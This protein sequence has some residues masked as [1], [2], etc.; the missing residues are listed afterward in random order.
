MWSDE[1]DSTAI[2]TNNWTVVTGNGCGGSSGC[3][4]GNNEKQFYT[5]SIN[6]VNVTGGNL[7]LTARYQKN[8]QSSGSD[9]TSGK[10]Y[11]YQKHSWKYG[12]YEARIKVPSASAVWPAFWMLSD[13]NNWPQSGEIDILETQNKNPKKA[14]QTVHFYCTPC[15]NHQYVYNDYN[16]GTDWSADY[17]IYA[18]DWAPQEIKFSVDG[19]VTKTITPA[20]IAG[21]GATASDW[22]FDDS[23]F[24]I[25]LNLAVGGTYTGNATP[26]SSD[27]PVSMYV[28]YVR[29]YTSGSYLYVG[30]KEL[31]F[32][33]DTQTYTAS[34][35][36][37]NATY[38]WTV[39]SGASIESGQGTKSI[40]VK[41]NSALKGDISCDITPSGCSM[42]TAKLSVTAIDKSCS[43]IMD[44][45]EN[46]R[47]LSGA[48][49]DGSLNA[50]ITNSAK[51]GSNSSD[52]CASYTRNSGSQYDILGFTKFLVA[53][54]DD[55]RKGIRQ[56]TMDVK[57]SA[58]QGTTI[59]IEFDKVADLSK[60]WPY[61][62]HSQYTATTGAP[63]TWTK[64]TFKW[65]SSPDG[66][67]KG[68]DV[69]KIQIL[70]NSNSFTN[71]TYYFDNL[72]IEGTPATSAITGNTT[73]C[74]NKKGVAYSVT[75]M[76]G[77]TFNW[78]VPSGATIASGQ[79]TKNITVDFDT[80]SGNVS[81]VETSSLLCV[82]NTV[83]KAITVAKQNCNVGINEISN[84]QINAFPNPF[85]E[86]ISLTFEHSLNSSV[87]LTIFNLNGS[88]AQQHNVKTN[89]TINI[90]EDLAQGTY[91][92]QA[93][94]ADQVKTLRIVKM[95]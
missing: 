65:V 95:D 12:H 69:D 22:T 75:G 91:I 78:T 86:R 84:A 23:P 46:N 32:T 42:T 21:K 16:T 25:I 28:D 76:S 10:I 93:Q 88:V 11:T 19:V 17:H 82:G 64:L 15:G 94:Y 4:F 90:G 33:N 14:S 8:Y 24:Y 60:G 79:G 27:Y 2:N 57:T 68:S 3:G 56:F 62:R 30:G 74:Y 77:S 58:P 13:N 70:F 6:N 49:S 89:E 80:I 1:F 29:V 20:T 50:P 40:S 73:V 54:P 72:K 61:G 83:S 43:I 67:L 7:V 45:F 37:A 53:D 47:Y 41:Y 18:I 34:D 85:S 59:T 9:Y 87:Q 51:G 36:G 55:F 39:P 26:V 66:A 52:Y 31:N 48:S 71:H 35:A 81:V 38:N 92:V 5:S 44:D 63:N